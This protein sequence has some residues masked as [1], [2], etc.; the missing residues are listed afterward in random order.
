MKFTEVEYR[1]H[2][3]KETD[4]I[5]RLLFKLKILKFI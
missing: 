1:N 4:F 3:L 5:G 2:V